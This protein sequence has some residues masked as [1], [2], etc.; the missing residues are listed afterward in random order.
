MTV[1]PNKSAGRQHRLRSAVCATDFGLARVTG[2]L[3]E[4]LVGA[5]TV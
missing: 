2:S 4:F 3:L 1:W 5:I